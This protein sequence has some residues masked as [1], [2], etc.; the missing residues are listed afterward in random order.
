MFGILTGFDVLIANPPYGANID[1]ILSVLRPRYQEVIQNYADSFK[2]FFQLGLELAATNGVLTY[3]SPNV[4]LSQPRYKDLRKY[5]LRYRI[6]RLVNL[7]ENVFEQVVPVCLSFIANERAGIAY[8]FADLT[9]SNKFQG[10][11]T[12]VHYN[13]VSTAR[14]ASFKDLSLYQADALKDG[15]VYFDEALEI[16]DAGIQYHR[17]GIGLKNKG[18]NDLYE[19]LFSPSQKQFPRCKPVWYGRLIDRYWMDDRTDEFF[20]LEYENILKDN[21]SV[22]FTRDA[23]ATAPKI[24]WRQT[25]S[26]LQA[27]IDFENRWF[28]NTIQCAFVKKDYQSRIDLH[29]LLGVVN[30]KYIAFTYN[31]LVREAGRVFPQV[32]IT[33][34]KKLPLAIP[35]KQ[36]QE[37]LAKMVK[38]ILAAKRGNMSADTSVLEREID[39]Q[40]YTLYGLT[41]EEIKIVDDWKPA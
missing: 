18:G 2:M 25:A 26:R 41:P 21:E 40:V 16:K 15:Q 10:D 37:Q 6:M 9:D 22:S 8:Q 39:Q 36:Q 28:R 1:A 7:G 27:T 14:V 34:V 4:F 17:S 11:F 33:H 3:I 35:P 5:L 13:E 31:K 30:S 12:S 20:N 38:A 24:L 19:R 29:Y 32:K 23:F